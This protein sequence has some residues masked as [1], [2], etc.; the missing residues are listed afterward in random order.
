[1]KRNLH[2]AIRSTAAATTR[3]AGAQ[4]F[5][6]AVTVAQLALALILL[7]GTGLMLRTF[8]NLQRVDGGFDPRHVVTMNV[9]LRDAAYA[10][11][12]AR[13]FWTR[14]EQR[15]ATLPG[16][17]SAALTSAL[18]PIVD[19]FGWSTPIPGYDPARGGSIRVGAGGL[20][21]V[22]YYQVVGTSYFG[23]LK[24]GLVAGRL[25]DARDA[26][27]APNVAIIN[28]TMGRA[29]WG[30]ESPI[31]K[32]LVATINPVPHT[33][34]GVVADVK[35]SGVDEPVGTAVYLPYAQVPAGTGLLRAPF[36]AVRAAGTPESIVTVMRRA[37]REVDESLPLAQV[38]TLDDVVAGSQS[39]PR[40]LALVLT[41]F[42]G[43][44]LALAA[45]GIY[46]VVS[47][48][49][50]ERTKEFGIR[51]ALGA[52]PAAVRN[53]ELGRGLALAAAGVVL[54]IGGAY[55]LT[56]LLAGFLFAVPANDLPT[57]AAVAALLAL[58]AVGSSYVAA[59]RATKVNPLVALRAE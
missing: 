45:V 28:E 59:Q 53:L 12:G 57:F 48:S 18:P 55:A 3:A 58:V 25:F 32:Q 40:F 29:I 26:A 16:V 30:D 15:L 22:D 1:V 52:Q 51:M 33:I 5:R 10:G 21:V 36:I 44:S 4:R 19:G 24:I 39:R 38:R 2:G 11:E 49:V 56:R 54:G 23:T 7:T 42:A 14:V 6:Q 34:V 47:Y 20:P 17:E 8:W 41:L 37:V 50:M 35:N 27:G 46:G 43:V 9:A 31:G 13:G